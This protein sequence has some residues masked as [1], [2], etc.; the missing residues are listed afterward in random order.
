[1]H[2]ER[3][4]S[5]S[6]S[7]NILRASGTKTVTDPW[8][9]IGYQELLKTGRSLRKQSN[10]PSNSSSISKSKKS[11]TKNEKPGNSWA[12]ST[13][14]SHQ[15]S[16][17]TINH[18]YPSMT[19]VLW[20]LLDQCP[21]TAQTI[22]LT[23]GYLVENMSYV[24]HK[25]TWQRTT[26]VFYQLFIL[27]IHGLCYNCASY[28]NVHVLSSCPLLIYLMSYYSS[29]ICLSQGQH[30]IYMCP[31]VIPSTLL[32]IS[33]VHT[34]TMCTPWETMSLDVIP[35]LDSSQSF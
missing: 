30:A 2:G 14:A 17:T 28:P 10:P 34:C 5:L 29:T 23:G 13:S 9:I 25:R 15:P 18:A 1:M 21:M 3:M 26:T 12:R 33:I 6:I 4:L 35:S 7:L 27:S 11:P 19:Y 8:G 31:D 24:I 22:N 16:N 20:Q 32:L